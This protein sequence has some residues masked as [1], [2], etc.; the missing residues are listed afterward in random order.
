MKENKM[1][2]NIILKLSDGRLIAITTPVFFREGDPPI[3]VREIRVSSPR[4]I[5]ENCSWENQDPEDDE[6]GS[7]PKG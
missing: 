7:R 4:E 5:P 3:H 6:N 1:Y 2:Q